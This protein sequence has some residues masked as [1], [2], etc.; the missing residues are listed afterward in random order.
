MSDE[1]EDLTPNEAGRELYY[2][3]KYGRP[4]RSKPF[5]RTETRRITR[6]LPN[7]EIEILEQEFTVEGYE[8]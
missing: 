8:E 1:V 2:L 3:M 4:S 6:L 5:R 7:G